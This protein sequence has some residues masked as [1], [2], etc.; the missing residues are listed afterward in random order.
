[1]NCHAQA[2]RVFWF[3]CIFLIRMSMNQF[4]YMVNFRVPMRGPSFC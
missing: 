1:M 3:G 4:M 2:L